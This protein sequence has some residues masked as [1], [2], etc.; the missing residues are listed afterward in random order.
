MFGFR[1]SPCICTRGYHWREDIVRGDRRRK[2]NPFRWDKVILKLPGSMQ[3]DSRKSWVYKLNWDTQR[4]TSDFVTFVDDI[5]VIVGN[6]IECTSDMCQIATMLNYLGEQNAA[7]KIREASQ[8][9][10]T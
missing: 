2:H 1:P 7:R 6:Y 5:R 4:V 9:P 8:I 10:G 3:F